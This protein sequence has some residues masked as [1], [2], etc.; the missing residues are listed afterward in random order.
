MKTNTKSVKNVTCNERI[1]PAIVLKAVKAAGNKGITSVELANRYV[2]E[3]NA[4]GQPRRGAARETLEALY[5][6][7]KIQLLAGHKLIAYANGV[8]VPA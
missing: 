5:Q 3:K 6:A 4:K 7:G 2:K 8:K 1:A